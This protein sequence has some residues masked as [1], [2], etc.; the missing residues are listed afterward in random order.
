LFKTYDINEKLFLK[1]KECTEDF[2]IY[3][4]Y[5]FG[6]V[7]KFY[8]KRNKGIDFNKLL[9]SFDALAKKGHK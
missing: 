3:Y 8:V 9:M 4:L 2:F 7:K 6:K 5:Y 1:V